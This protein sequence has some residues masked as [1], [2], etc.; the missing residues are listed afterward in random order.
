MSK[1]KISTADL[2]S[3]R[4]LTNFRTAAGSKKNLIHNVVST[5]SFMFMNQESDLATSMANREAQRGEITGKSV[6]TRLDHNSP[7]GMQLNEVSERGHVANTS[8]HTQS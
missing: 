2:K 1:Q 7:T 3:E 5:S 8:G 4:T 6:N